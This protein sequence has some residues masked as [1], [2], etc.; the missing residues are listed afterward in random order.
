[1]VIHILEA[2]ELLKLM[3]SMTWVSKQSW[4]K[5][6]SDRS[7][8]WAALLDFLDGHGGRC[9][10]S[11]RGDRAGTEGCCYRGA[12]D[13]DRLKYRRRD[14]FCCTISRIHWP[15]RSSRVDGEG[16]WVATTAQ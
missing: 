15:D 1:M 11:V 5:V 6:G 9:G 4:Y 16:S 10:E 8:C 13:D 2:V 14:H 3:E 7:T 12:G